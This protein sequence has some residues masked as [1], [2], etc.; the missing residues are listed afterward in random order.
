MIFGGDGGGGGGGGTGVLT[1]LNANS[2]VNI[3][4]SF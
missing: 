3:D 2:V 4:N 1:F